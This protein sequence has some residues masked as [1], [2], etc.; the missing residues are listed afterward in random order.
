MSGEVNGTKVDEFVCVTVLSESVDLVIT[1]QLLACLRDFHK[2][3]FVTFT[4]KVLIIRHNRLA[5]NVWLSGR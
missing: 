4:S 3:I 1:H 5:D 2:Q